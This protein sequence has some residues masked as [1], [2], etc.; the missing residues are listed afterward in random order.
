MAQSYRLDGAEIAKVMNPVPPDLPAF[1]VC[2][3]RHG[4]L[5]QLRNTSFFLYLE[6][7]DK[8]SNP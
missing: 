3:N 6:A 4:M 1:K 8:A 5:K 2:A 7:Q